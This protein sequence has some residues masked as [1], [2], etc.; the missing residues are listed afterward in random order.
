M[1]KELYEELM[2][3]LISIEVKFDMSLREVKNNLEAGLD[4]VRSLQN[5]I[6]ALRGT[7]VDTLEDRFESSNKVPKREDVRPKLDIDGLLQEID[8]RIAELEEG[9]KNKKKA[10]ESERFDYEHLGLKNFK[11]VRNIVH[12][13]DRKSKDIYKKIE[14]RKNEFLV[15]LEEGE[16]LHV[17]NTNLDKYK[18]FYNKK[19]EELNN[20]REEYY[21]KISELSDLK[22]SKDDKK[23]IIEDGVKGLLRYLSSLMFDFSQS[24][25]TVK[26]YNVG[27]FY[28]IY[29]E[30]KHLLEI[31]Q[32]DEE[33]FNSLLES[34]LAFSYQVDLIRFELD[35]ASFDLVESSRVNAVLLFKE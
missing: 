2:D 30:M 35:Y 16:T 34:L 5:K 25:G 8:G 21:E 29:T 22:S 32:A 14:L 23:Q 13:V 12:N 6:K 7:P 33:K 18:D 9:K 26:Y 15:T 11:D 10:K 19:I 31:K 1:D 4:E 27:R 17:R 28:S 3:S 20:K 24:K